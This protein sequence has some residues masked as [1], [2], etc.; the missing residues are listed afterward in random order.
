[1]LK[2]KSGFC[3]IV[4]S[5]YLHYSLALH[6][7]LVKLHSDIDF[8]ILIVDLR[9]GLKEAIES[10]Y[11]DINLVFP[12]ELCL[13][14]IG[15]E[16]HKKYFKTNINAFRWSMKPVFIKHLLEERKYQ[17]VVYLDSD[18]YFYNSF[19]FLL[20]ELDEHN[21]LLT[22]HWRSSDPY[23]DLPNFQFL[24]TDGL[25]NGGF[26]AANR[27]ALKALE[28][29]AN[30]CALICEKESLN[31]RY[32]DQT[33]LNL[34]PIYFNEVYIVRHKG[35]N[36]ANWNMIECNRS[37]DENSASVIIADKF[38][39]IFIHFTKST[40]NGILGG[41]DELLRPYYEEYSDVVN[42]Y[43]ENM[44][45]KVQKKK[46]VSPDAETIHENIKG[47]HY[48]KTIAI[49]SPNQDAYSETFIHAHK[50]LNFK[51]K[52][53]H[54]GLL[55]TKLE[56]SANLFK[57]D[58]FEKIRIRIYPTFNLS[59]HALINSLKREKVDCV[60]AEYG[61]TAC[62]TLK[63]VK[64]LKLPL[65]VHFHGYDASVTEVLN[66]YREAYHTVFSYAKAII[67]VSEKMKRGLIEQGCPANKITV[68]IYGP[69]PVFFEN[70]PLYNTL[71]FITVGRFVEKKSP[72]LIIAAFKK[73]V[74]EVPNVKLVMVGE[75]PLL[76]VCKNLVRALELE[77]NIEFK[78][79][80]SLKQ[81]KALFEES[82]AFVQHSV[83]AENGDSEG[84]PVVILE[85]QAAALPVISTLHAGIPD[86]VI[87]NETGLLVEELNTE[88]MARNMIRFSKEKGLAEK[89]G[90]AGRKR[91]IENF[92]MEKHLQCL[93]SIIERSIKETL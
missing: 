12:E 66:Q 36:V 26:I 2:R 49:F 54:S 56:E 18:I 46:E 61:P 25:Y 13:N 84:T 21:I 9:K 83:V 57:F 30:A 17:K 72:Y 68:S 48:G 31:G 77:K 51:I 81:I 69:N 11:K 7:S 76:S 86:V 39:I 67:A 70:V 32:Y 74:D 62:A 47:K 5:D 60:L 85:A 40:I 65:V 10:K 58:I 50:N 53:Y 29:W 64:Y 34:L 16:I 37:L 90:K 38:P 27:N 8:Y 42:Y 28:W 3:T 79:V 19:R 80:Q 59:E 4:T 6:H 1:M 91:V 24:Y 73:V 71:Q 78:G 41:G 55:P 22:P 93:E 14:G 75:G 88:E 63:V 23:K 89:F 45:E 33:H 20:D 82:L 44:P 35:C 15:N 87:N 92:T 43:H 52:F